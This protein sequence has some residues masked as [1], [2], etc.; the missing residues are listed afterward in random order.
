MATRTV[1]SNASTGSES[2]EEIEKRSNRFVFSLECFIQ[3]KVVR[4]F[5]VANIIACVA[6]EQNPGYIVL[7][8]RSVN[9]DD[10]LVSYDITALFTNIPVDETIQILADK[11]FTNDWF[12][13]THGLQLKKEQLIELL[14]VAVN[15]QLFQLDGKLYEQ[16]DGVAMGSPLGPLLANTFM[17]SLEE[18][19][20]EDG[21]MPSYYKRYV[22]NTLAIMPGLQAATSFL[23][24]L[25]SKHPSLTFT[26]E[27]S[28]DN[29]LLFLGMKISKN[30][31]NL[32]GNVYR[33][34]TNTG[35]YLHYDSHVG[36]PNKNDAV[37]SLSTIVYLESFHR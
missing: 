31:T 3:T 25:N 24:V 20:Q 6:D 37:Q 30:G 36:R 12:N 21:Q 14:E 2:T 22:D 32:I 7:D 26:M 13:K 10:V 34:P 1:R 23:E 15:D 29:T 16:I 33:K 11:A 9:D 8:S 27:T 4:R 17:C 18:K 19:L 35:L 5:D 28:T